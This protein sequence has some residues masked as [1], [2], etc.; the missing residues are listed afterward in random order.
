MALNTL[1]PSRQFPLAGSLHGVTTAAGNIQPV[2]APSIRP[3]RALCSREFRYSFR[4][5]HLGLMSF[6][7]PP[8]LLNSSRYRPV[9]T[10][11]TCA[12]ST[13]RAAVSPQTLTQR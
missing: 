5:S 4:P 11:T 9:F 2:M 8:F 3:C 13:G 12:T 1:L 7:C 6:W 10:T